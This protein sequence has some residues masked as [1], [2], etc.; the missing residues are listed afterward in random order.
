MSERR[1]LDSWKD[2]ADY[3][4]RDIRTCRRYERDL[5]LPVHRLEPT[6]K[7]RVFAYT[8]EIDIWRDKKLLQVESRSSSAAGAQQTRRGWRQWGW[9]AAGTVMILSLAAAGIISLA[10]RKPPSVPGAPRMANAFKLTTGLSVEDYPGFSPDGRSVVYQSDQA[11]NWDIWVTGMEGGRSVN[12]TPDS[13]AA[14]L[15][16]TWSPDG[17]WISFYSAREGSGYFIMPSAGGRA[18]KITAYQASVV[19]SVV[20]YAS[21]AVWSPDSK[22][23][24]YALGQ[25]REPWIEIVTLSDGTT[26]KLDLPKR[27]LN[28]VIVDIRWSPDGRWLAYERSYSRIAAPS[29]MWLTRFSDGESRR[30]TDGSSKA[31]SPSWSPDSRALYFVSD[32]AGASDLWRITIDD[33]GYPQGAPVQVS[34]GMEMTDAVLSVNGEKLAYSMGRSVRN[35]FRAPILTDRPATWADSVQLTR[36]GAAV[37]TMDVSRAGQ[38][39]LSSDRS[40]NWDI[41]LCPDD[42]ENLQ[43]LIMDPA[44]DAGPRWRPDGGG[45]AFYSSRTGH[46]QIWTLPIGGGPAR[47]LTEGRTESL[48]PAWSPDGSEI[49]KE[50]DGLSV[51]PAVGGP[52]RRLTHEAVDI[53]PDCSPDGRWIVFSSVRDGVRRLWRI[54]SSG[55]PAE[56][57]TKGAD[58]LSRWMPRWTPDGTQIFFIALGDQ[59][60]DV[61]ALSVADLEERVLIR[62]TERRG[63]LGHAGLATDGRFI[64]FTWEES[65]GDIWVA[66]IVPRPR[67]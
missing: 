66:D 38:L 55:G 32:R 48:Y 8:D 25:R 35:A 47:Q 39:I 54:P 28:N 4:N 65:R 63:R 34:S 9:W 6:S 27:P 44:L 61:R 60:N 15:Y 21:S 1:V 46:R 67:D 2:I 20:S 12:R 22:C 51:I 3:L 43:A 19:G 23:L 42:G 11:G 16:P 13:P 41:Y 14:D 64:Y 49:V 57:L 50:G 53:H 7:A 45:I 59:I 17:R 58:G 52:E 36:D 56:L 18:R 24:A 40:G 5:S 33:D 30:L 29:E 31:R 10:V 26:E 37:E 62:L